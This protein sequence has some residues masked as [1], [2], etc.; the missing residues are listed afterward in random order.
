MPQVEFSNAP[1][2]TNQSGNKHSPW[3]HLFDDLFLSGGRLLF[4][5]PSFKGKHGEDKQATKPKEVPDNEICV[6]YN[7]MMNM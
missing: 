3:N 7:L 5:L 2:S 4:G 1:I 6:D